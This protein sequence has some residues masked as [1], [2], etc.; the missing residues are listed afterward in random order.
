MITVEPL[1]YCQRHEVEVERQVALWTQLKND[2]LLRIPSGSA[3]NREECR[4]I[5]T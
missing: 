5:N 2:I 1:T 4:D 3:S